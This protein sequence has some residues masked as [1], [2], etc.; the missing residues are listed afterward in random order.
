[1]RLFEYDGSPDMN[2]VDEYGL[3]AHAR[4]RLGLKNKFKANRKMGRPR[5]PLQTTMPS[6]LRIESLRSRSYEVK[7]DT[8]KSIYMVLYK[9]IPEFAKSIV[10]RIKESGP[11]GYV[12]SGSWPSSG[13]Q[14]F[15]WEFEVYKDGRDY[16]AKYNLWSPAGKNIGETYRL[17]QNRAMRFAPKFASFVYRDIDVIKNAG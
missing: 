3:D 8:A 6:S 10:G 14:V 2:D 17:S 5:K 12:A 4:K 1:M 15:D 9:S 16:I 7:P 13:R 11:D